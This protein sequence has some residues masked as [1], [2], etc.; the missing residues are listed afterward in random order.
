MPRHAPKALD[1]RAKLR[2]LRA[3]E[4]CPSARDR[5]I[6]LLP[7]FAGTRIAEISA[8]D[9]ADVALSAR[10]GDVH[11]VGKGEKSRTVPVH[12]KLREALAAWLAERPS[13]PTAR[14]AAL[15]TSGRATRMTTDALADVVARI[16][17]AAS[18]DDEVTSHRLR[19]T[20]GTEFVAASTS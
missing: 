12:P 17:A 3:V 8:L 11:L 4:A 6:A 16:T 7:P 19:H 14:T 15:F 5:A 9:V 2:Y 10:K 1:P 20:F 18:L 13:R